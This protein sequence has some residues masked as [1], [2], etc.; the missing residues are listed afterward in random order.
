MPGKKRRW[1]VGQRVRFEPNAVSM[2]LYP[3]SYHGKFPARGSL[4][5][6]TSVAF[7]GGKRRTSIPGPGGGLVYIAWDHGVTMG[8][9]PADIERASAGVR[10]KN[11]GTQT[12]VVAFLP[13]AADRAAQWAEKLRAQG[14]TVKTKKKDCGGTPIGPSGTPTLQARMHPGCIV[15][16]GTLKYRASKASK[17]PGNPYKPTM[18]RYAVYVEEGRKPKVLRHFHDER[19]A[20]A[21]VEQ[22]AEGKR[23]KPKIHAQVWDN[24]RGGPVAVQNPAPCVK[25]SDFPAD[26][27]KLTPKLRHELVTL[28]S[29]YPLSWLRAKRKSL[30]TLKT[31][32][33]QK[34][35]D[36][37]FADAIRMRQQRRNPDERKDLTPKQK[38]A[39]GAFIRELK[40]AG[41][42]RGAAYRADQKRRERA[43]RS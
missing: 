34:L 11:P 3:Q 15:V 37:M 36:K 31:D 18:A 21:H 24:V 14:W 17:N 13:S 33:V 39:I 22:L 25:L 16:K 38:K 27:N 28:M 10:A 7:P 20:I 30:P 35:A 4:G 41:E 42:H 29:Q 5:K 9:A 40:M 19:N 32:R 26:I 1:S 23:G 2:M 12:S 6:V 8:M 43:R